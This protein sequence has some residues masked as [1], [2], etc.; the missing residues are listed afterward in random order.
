MST[1]TNE[2]PPP[3]LPSY[4]A[5]LLVSFGGP[6]GPDDV[7]PFLQNVL[8]GKNV[9]HERMLEVAEHY[10][11]FGGI[12][13]INDQCR[14]LLQAM[15][16]ELQDNG[17]DLPV[18][19]G[20]R[21]WHP[22]LEDTLREMKDA[23]IKR[24]LAFV[25][26]SSSSYSGCRQYR[27]DIANAQAAIGEGAPHVDKIRAFYNHPDFIAAS[28]D[29]VN[30]ALDKIPQERRGDVHIAFTA[31]SIPNSMSDTSDYVKQLTESSRLVAES[32]GVASDRWQLVYQSRSGP[33]QV[34][35]LEPDISDHLRELKSK[36]V[37]DVIIVPIGFLSD[38]IEVLFDLDEEARDTCAEIGLNM[39]R[40]ATVGIHPQFVTMIR[41]LIEE[42]VNG[43]EAESSGLYGPNHNVCPLDCCP[44]PQRPGRSGTSV[45]DPPS[46]RPTCN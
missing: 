18:Y 28:T 44:A 22:M 17:I 15:K 9:P 6:E 34:P 23:G 5:I 2:A 33:P 20:N 41:N 13:P 8:R 43:R 31:H 38:H 29:G 12:S 37:N 27:E 46:R 3:N 36:N 35:W 1:A 26:S 21:N 32:V 30:N 4:D 14:A 42:R 7:M 16:T 40:A 39:V 24:A 19:W 10:R 11:H 45:T 25:T